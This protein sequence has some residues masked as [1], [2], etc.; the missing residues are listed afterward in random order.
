ML[1]TGCCQLLEG[2]N[3]KLGKQLAIMTGY[4]IHDLP[5]NGLKSEPTF[6]GLNPLNAAVMA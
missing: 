5:A 3:L 1:D 6:D 4:S 2:E